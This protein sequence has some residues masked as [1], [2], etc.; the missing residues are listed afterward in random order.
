VTAHG[1]T[2]KKG[3]EGSPAAIV[4]EETERWGA[5][6]KELRPNLVRALVAT[7]GTYDG[8]EDAIQEAFAAAIHQAPAELRSPEG[9]LFVVALNKLRNQ[10][11]RARLAARLRL[12]P[13]PNPHE[14]DDVLR[15]A[16]VVCT[17]QLLSS[18]ERELLVA[19]YYVGL[20]Q[21]EIAR[22]LGIARGTVAS[23]I[24]RAAARFRELEK[25]DG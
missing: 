15:R 24:S 12:A 8:V 5:L 7:A 6:Y 22:H 21:D 11:R 4:S 19:K 9:W 17:L 18:R 25:R 3:V 2:G 14:L 20:T 13:P 10:Q 16:D 23:A 1:T